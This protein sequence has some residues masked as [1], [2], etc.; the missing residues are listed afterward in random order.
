MLG[1]LEMLFSYIYLYIYIFTQKPTAFH[2][3]KRDQ[4]WLDISRVLFVRTRLIFR[5]LDQTS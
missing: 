4:R 5:H 1:I 2:E 3:T